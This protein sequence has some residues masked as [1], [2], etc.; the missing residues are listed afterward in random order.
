V[1]KK[2]KN[3]ARPVEMMQIRKRRRIGMNQE[4]V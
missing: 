4:V 2:R 3:E 1:I